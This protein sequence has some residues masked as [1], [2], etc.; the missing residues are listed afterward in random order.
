MNDVIK[1]LQR[2][3]T[4]DKQELQNIKIQHQKKVELLEA[5]NSDLKHKNVAKDGTINL[6]RNK[7]EELQR[8]NAERKDEE[9]IVITEVNECEENC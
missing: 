7:V 3:K 2:E 5:E 9:E 6:L 4:N 8:T 1:E